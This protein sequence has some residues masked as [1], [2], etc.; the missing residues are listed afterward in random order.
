MY[1]REID[2]LIAE[3]GRGLVRCTSRSAGHTKSDL[4]YATSTTTASFSWTA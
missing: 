2:K 4:C 3:K 1:N